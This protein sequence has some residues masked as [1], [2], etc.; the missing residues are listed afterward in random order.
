MTAS[1]QSVSPE[2]INFDSWFEVIEGKRLVNIQKLAN[3]FEKTEKDCIEIIRNGLELFEGDH[4]EFSGLMPE[5]SHTYHTFQNQKRSRGRPQKHHYLTRNG[6]LMFVSQLE[7]QAYEEGVRKFII[8]F[9]RWLTKTG[10]DVLDGKLVRTEKT[11][12]YHEERLNA[13]THHK[14]LSALLTQKIIPILP[15]SI[16]PRTVYQQESR[17][18]NEVSIG[19]HIHRSNDKLNQTG[20][21]AKNTA[22]TSDITLLEAG[23][24][25]HSFRRDTVQHVVDRLYPDRNKNDM[26]LTDQEKA[27]LVRKCPDSQRGISDFLAVV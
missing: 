26:L 25:N 16:N 7:Y 13:A 21:H 11:L 18:L 14:H 9:K 20:L 23:I 6:C 2:E 17:M 10:G 3:A 27:R 4:F 19:E 15:K 22:Y 24:T 5:K 1:I 8:A 12:S